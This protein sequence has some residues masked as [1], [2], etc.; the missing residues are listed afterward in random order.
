MRDNSPLRLIVV[1]AA[2]DPDANVW[3][4]EGSNPL[5]GLNLEA[6]TMDELHDKLPA[7]F[8]DLLEATVPGGDIA[9]HIVCHA[10]ITVR[11]PKGAES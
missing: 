3:W 2:H 6:V 1:R 11:I 10:R 7:A 9:I 5:D 8:I 4:I